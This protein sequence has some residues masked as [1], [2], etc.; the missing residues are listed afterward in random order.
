MIPAE[1]AFRILPSDHS[2]QRVRDDRA[3]CMHCLS[4]QCC[5]SEDPIYLTAFDIFRLAAYFDMSPAAFLHRFTQDRFDGEDSDLKRKPWIEDPRT[6]VVTYLRR[7]AN[8]PTSPCIFLKYI[9]QPDGTPRRV[10]SVHAARPL[11]C[12]EYYYD[13]CKTR[14]TGELAS[15]TARAYLLVRDRQVTLEQAEAALQSLLPAEAHATPIGAQLE[16]AFWTE[17][18]R[19][20]DVDAT[21]NE[22][23][24]WIDPAVHQDA[25]DVKLN[26]VLSTR[27]LRLEEKYGPEPWGE[28]LDSYQ[29]GLSF[30]G[31]D[32]Y[33][34]L[35]QISG[36]GPLQRLFSAGD[37]PHYVANRFLVPGAAQPARFPTLSGRRIAGLL[38]R[39]PVPRD[40]QIMEA[41]LRASNALVRLAAFAAGVGK[42][43]EFEPE[44]AFETAL[45]AAF[46]VLEKAHHPCWSVHPGLAR[47]K[48]WAGSRAKLPP[49]WRK[50]LPPPP[51]P[52]RRRIDR[53]L[54]TQRPDGSWLSNPLPAECSSQGD[55]WRLLLHSTASALLELRPAGKAALKP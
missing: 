40:R 1:S 29:A 23:A 38:K 7:R 6:S 28:Q 53:W 4:G 19:A 21:N 5:S 11:S 45:L 15:I 13:T 27:N 32:E 37:F 51:K 17:V 50:R 52:S 54:A 14:W 49:A 10:C 39:Y 42:L 18:R 33:Q 12:R 30:P 55:Y 20:L 48:A 2:Q 24:A 44:G 35:M 22:P 25:L 43:L 9:L 47:A 16:L 26:R 46:A 31:S 41:A 36:G 34:R 3:V 8:Y